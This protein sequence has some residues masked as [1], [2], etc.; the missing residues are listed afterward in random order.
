MLIQIR[1]SNSY[2]NIIVIKM[3][4]DNRADSDI[5]NHWG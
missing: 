5:L 4:A 3:L 1:F 2:D